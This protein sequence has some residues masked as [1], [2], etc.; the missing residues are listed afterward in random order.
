MYAVIQ[1]GG[2]QYRIAENDV[3]RVEKL[4]GEAGEAVELDLRPRPG[5]AVGRAPLR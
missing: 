3:I 5:R 4:L 2:K 1:T